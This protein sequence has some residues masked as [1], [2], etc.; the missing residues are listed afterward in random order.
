[1]SE[2]ILIASGSKLTGEELA[3]EYAVS[4]DGMKAHLIPRVPYRASRSLGRHE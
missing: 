2:S 3:G 1:V 4:K